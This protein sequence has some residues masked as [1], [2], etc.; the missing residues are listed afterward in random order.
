MKI[1][2]VDCLFIIS[3]HIY[4]VRLLGIKNYHSLCFIYLKNNKGFHCLTITVENKT[5]F[6]LCL[7]V[8]HEKKTTKYRVIAV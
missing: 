3:G 6:A 1:G 2:R 8:L 4:Y 7:S 5:I